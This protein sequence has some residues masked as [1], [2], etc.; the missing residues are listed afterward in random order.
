[1]VML[2][3]SLYLHTPPP[4]IFARR[5]L[6]TTTTTTMDELHP[7]RRARS[8][9]PKR[10]W[11]PCRAHIPM[12]EWSRGR[13]V[14]CRASIVLARYPF[15]LLAHCIR[16]GMRVLEW[17]NTASNVMPFDY[18]SSNAIYSGVDG[19]QLPSLFHIYLE[20]SAV[21]R[22]INNFVMFI[23]GDGTI[24]TH[25]MMHAPGLH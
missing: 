1:M 11:Q 10:E 21:D 22:S 18:A 4:R 5:R 7:R 2:S 8:M 12:H 15:V 9:D 23:I 25:V 20:P 16:A 14:F 19:K 6:D 3:L 24:L 13:T 17:M